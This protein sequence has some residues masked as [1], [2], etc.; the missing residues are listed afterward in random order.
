[1]SLHT[2][3]LAKH[4]GLDV[5]TVEVDGNH[6]NHVERAIPHSIAFFQ[7]IFAQEIAPWKGEMV[8][9]LARK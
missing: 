3:A 6:G 1:M 2:A 7:K 5:E 8:S 4:R 9:A